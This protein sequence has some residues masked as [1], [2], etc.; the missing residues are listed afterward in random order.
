MSEGDTVKST[1]GLPGTAESITSDL[2]EL[3]VKPGMVLMVH[4]SLAKM[5][6]IVGGAQAVIM[7]IQNVLGESG[8][9]VT[10][11]FTSSNGDPTHWSKPPVPEAWWKVIIDHQ[12]AYDPDLSPTRE[13]GAVAETFRGHPDTLRSSHPL[14]SFAAQ[15]PL[16]EYITS[17][18]PLSFPLGKN[19]PVEK[20]YDNDA[21]VL[22][23]GVPHDNNSSMHLA[24][25][26]A[27]IPGKKHTVR[28]SA[29]MVDGKREWVKY[30]DFVYI[31]DLLPE[32]GKDFDAESKTLKV[33]KIAQ[34]ESRLFSQREMV[35]F[36]IDWLENRM[37]E[38]IKPFDG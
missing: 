25:F 37:P 21:W 16:A 34:A 12:P 8:T 32:I 13:I 38:R 18:Q 3:G 35:D 17:D 6:W 23:L 28:A 4:T 24:E 7:A 31:E 30:R 26:R 22:L 33:G 15:G 14:G 20:M 9:M 2:I 1:P 27:D 11:T 5:G 10:P 36:A 29:M 19:S